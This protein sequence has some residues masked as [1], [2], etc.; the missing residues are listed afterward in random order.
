MSTDA[1]APEPAG[2]FICRIQVTQETAG[3]GTHSLCWDFDA[4]RF[5]EV[6][7]DLTA[8]HGPA[9][10]EQVLTYD[11]LLQMDRNHASDPMGLRRWPGGETPRGGGEPE[12]RREWLQ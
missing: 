4:D 6:V 3:N 2:P 8:R 7:A 5:N 1:A 9:F 11:E 10:F 12:Y